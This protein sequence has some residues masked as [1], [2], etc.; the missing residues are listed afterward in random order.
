[1]IPVFGSEVYGVSDGL[2]RV[3]SLVPVDAWFGV[4]SVICEV[5]RNEASRQAKLMPKNLIR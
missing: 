4:V 1:M 3:G 2:L 5:Y